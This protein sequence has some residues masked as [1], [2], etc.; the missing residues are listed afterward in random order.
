MYRQFER[1]VEFSNNKSDGPSYLNIANTN[2]LMGKIPDAIKNYGNS[3]KH[4]KNNELFE[5][6]FNRGICYRQIDQIENSIDDFLKAAELRKD[7]PYVQYRLGLNYLDVEDF[8]EARGRF[9]RAIELNTKEPMFYSSKA[10][11]LYLN[12]EYQSALNESWKA[13]ELFEEA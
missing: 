6:Y 3:I 8:E 10:L 9:D 5:A 7:E 12:Y 1:A 2:K 11:A 13:L 4:L